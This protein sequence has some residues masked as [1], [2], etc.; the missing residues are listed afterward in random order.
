MSDPDDLYT[1]RNLFW[2]GN[3]QA[4]INEANGLTK[5]SALLKNEKSEFLYRSY[6]ALGQYSII[7]S[8]IKDNSSTSL[9]LR[10]IRNL[11]VFLNDPNTKASSLAA[12]NEII[13]YINISNGSS[14]KSAI[15]IAS[16]FFIYDDNLKEV[17]RLSTLTTSFEMKAV[18]VQIYLRMDRLDLAQ[19]QLK[20]MKTLDE[21]HILTGLA[22]AWIHLYSGI[23]KAQEAAYIYEELIDKFGGSALLLNGLAVS[24]LHLAQY[25]EAETVLQEAL[26]KAPSDPDS[27]ANLIV[28]SQHLS[29]PAEVINR[30]LR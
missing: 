6:L 17:L 30:Y 4:A 11:A 2:S 27:L 19:Q 3:Y 29:R 21:D 28:V 12:M 22:T 13:K 10:A 15:L 16:V 26:T 18:L 25:D 5:L 23:A 8:E 7:L 9:G 14:E 1:L 24:K 20:A